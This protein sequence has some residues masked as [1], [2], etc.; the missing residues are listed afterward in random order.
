MDKIEA[1]YWKK[2]FNIIILVYFDLHIHI[3]D[4]RM[5]L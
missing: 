3:V 1:I 2:S 5:N 4:K